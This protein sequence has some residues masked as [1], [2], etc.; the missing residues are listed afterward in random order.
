[1]I[2]SGFRVMFWRQVVTAEN[3]LIADI[4]DTAVVLFNAGEKHDHICVEI[5][6]PKSDCV[7]FQVPE[8]CVIQ[9]PE[10]RLID[11]RLEVA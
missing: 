6:E 9:F 5:D 7:V 8:S 4:G 10:V 11:G 2:P 3:E 1:M